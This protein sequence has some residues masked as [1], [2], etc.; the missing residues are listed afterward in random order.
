MQINDDVRFGAGAGTA[1]GD[2][3]AGNGE[4]EPRIDSTQSVSSFSGSRSIRARRS[5][6]ASG[7]DSPVGHANAPAAE[8]A[9]TI[10]MCS[11]R[12]LPSSL[13][14]RVH[15]TDPACRS[16]WL[17]QTPG[18]TPHEHPPTRLNPQVSGES[19]GRRPDRMHD[20]IRTLSCECSKVDPMWQNPNRIHAVQGPAV[21]IAAVRRRAL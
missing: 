4:V 8:R 17:A 5:N 20:K 10:T 2:H 13:P 1:V 19:R 6:A 18:A 12:S 16:E 9:G 3:V 21:V 7:R 11:A 14:V 15:R